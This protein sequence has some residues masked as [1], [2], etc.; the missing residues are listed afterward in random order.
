MWNRKKIS[1][2]L[3]GVLLLLPG[4]GINGLPPVSLSD[5]GLVRDLVSTAAKIS[6]QRV[7]VRFLNRLSND[8]LVPLVP[9]ALE[10]LTFDGQFTLNSEDFPAN[11]GLEQSFPFLEAGEHLI[12]LVLRD[13]EQQ[14]Q[15]PLVVPKIEVEE[16]VV[17]VIL[18]FD[19]HSNTVRDVQVGY[20]QNGD[21]I[22]DP[23]RN[24]YRSSNGQSYLV[25]T[26]DGRTEEWTSP[27]EHDQ[28][29]SVPSSVDAPVA[30]GSEKDNTPTEQAP[31]T[32]ESSDQ[33]PPTIE[34][35]VP[36]PVPVPLPDPGS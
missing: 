20:D 3:S 17:L 9:D 11:Q 26:P 31:S 25:Q 10:S 33:A 7:Q 15:V 27:L 16:L 1:L 2:L 32:Q 34:I 28:Q 24:I 8:Q 14:V 21:M 29:E 4:C 23:D 36:V 13:S 19:A 6:R 30:P 5:A 35:P 22:L 18:S 12:D